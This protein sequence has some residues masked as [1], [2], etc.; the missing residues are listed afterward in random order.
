MQPRP[1]F[2]Y[3]LVGTTPIF[4][5]T[6]IWCFSLVLIKY[7]KQLETSQLPYSIE[8][9]IIAVQNALEARSIHFEEQGQ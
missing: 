4:S 6:Q 3:D 9:I 7:R 1:Y 8:Y 2:G 5:K